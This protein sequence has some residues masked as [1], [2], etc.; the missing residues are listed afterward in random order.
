MDDFVTVIYKF[1]ADIAAWLYGKLIFDRRKKFH[2][3]EQ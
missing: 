2:D 1:K 3:V